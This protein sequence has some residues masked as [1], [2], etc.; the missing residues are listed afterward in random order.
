MGEAFA[1]ARICNALS[2]TIQRITNQI[3]NK[4]RAKKKVARKKLEK[5]EVENKVKEQQQHDKNDDDIQLVLHQTM[6]A[7]QAD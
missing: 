4:R 5:E 1:V 3:N 7:I 2:S 6:C